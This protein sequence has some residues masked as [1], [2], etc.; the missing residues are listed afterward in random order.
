MVAA[1]RATARA[2]LTFAIAM[3]RRAIKSTQQ[4]CLKRDYQ[5][6]IDGLEKVKESLA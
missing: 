1:D 5:R 4:P 3:L 6:A 2:A